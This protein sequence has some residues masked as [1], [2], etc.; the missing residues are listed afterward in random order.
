M[1]LNTG[2]QKFL[3]IIIDFT[4]G[5]PLTINAGTPRE[6]TY[7][8]LIEMINP[9][10]IPPIT[11]MF[12]DL[13]ITSADA[14]DDEK[15]LEVHCRFLVGGE[16]HWF[17]L[18]CSP[19]Y[20]SFEKPMR[21][22]GTMCDVS[23]YL[24]TSGDDLVYNEFKKK[25]NIKLAELNKGAVSLD[26]VL[27]KAYLTSI[28]KPFAQAGMYSAVFGAQG[29]L[30]CTPKGQN[31]GLS[32]E[33]F[34]FQKKKSIRINHLVSGSWVIAARTQE[35]LD[36]QL[37][38]WETLVQTVSGMANAFVTV[39]QEMDNSQNANKL[40]SQNVEEQIL[41]NN[42]YDIIMRSHT[43][44]E[45]LKKVLSLV[46][47]YFKL[48]RIVIKDIEEISEEES[49]WYTDEKYKSIQIDR[50][51]L[52]SQDF[53]NISN[54]LYNVSSSF[55]D[56]TSN[57]L[58]KYSIKSYAVFKLFDSGSF[59]GMIVYETI[60][61]QHNWT[62]RER[63][64]LRNISQIISSILMR[65]RAQKKLEESQERILQLAFYDSIFQVPNRARLNRDLTELLN[66]DADGSIISFKVTNTRNLSAVNGHSYTDLLLRSVA[67]YL[68]RLPIKNLGVY[69]FTNSIFILNLPYCTGTEARSL[70]EMLL[71]RFSKPW[72]FDNSEHYIHCSIGIAYYPVNGKT[73]EDVCKAASVAMYRAREFK[74][75][76][77]MFY[78]GSLVKSRTLAA[79]LEKRITD[80][81]TNG[82]TGFSLNFQPAFSSDDGTVSY[83]ES[84]IRWNDEK[85][86]SIPNSTLFPL[87]EN[88]GIS[89]LI[90]N[91]V[92][93]QSCIFCKSV[94]DGGYADFQV[95][96]NLTASEL[97]SS[98]IIAGVEH[99]LAVSGL[100]PESLILEIPVKANLSYN[101]ST[102]IL[103]E[104]NS[105]GVKI[106]IDSYGT[107]DISLKVLKNS[108][109]S[110]I[111]IPKT[112]LT[113]SDDEFDRELINAIIILAHCK[114][115]KICIKG[116]E[117]QTQL[118]AVRCHS[119][120]SVQGYYCSRPL[121][122]E[123]A[124]KILAGT[125]SRQAVKT[126]L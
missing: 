38:L 62:Q 4:R 111:N 85:Y 56:G 119:I 72:L 93:E 30:I 18:S 88:I 64:Q 36:E 75:N 10:D 116:I 67:Q 83:C 69:Y 80:C 104:L 106:A 90:D 42:V 96:V 53:P 68:R 59:G 3:N 110:I 71:Y 108:Y 66:K 31:P 114:G 120:D 17:F 95:S 78:S 19:I 50:S 11:E 81:I 97:Q 20:G 9:D 27:D 8:S 65:K 51:D 77:Y 28:Q 24:E 21:F 1:E 6:I 99:A 34:A 79:T 39:L 124:Y 115:I 73:A 52:T 113:E 14:A 117:D 5:F 101:D 37:P 98:G 55:S 12:T 41:L 118:N 126:P 70:A 58:E 15:K 47:E 46:G 7:P 61:A 60:A 109:V 125:V 107:E 26:E 23:M 48:D 13:S 100:S 16:Y 121:S 92:L 82:M 94:Q 102:N 40:L 63:K 86:G 122:A 76:S 33:N 49:C 89:H 105:L 35:M 84:L 123:E 112:L 45:G 22:E 57:E 87:A 2:N 29:R 32:A 91:W 103:S 54:D 43:A 74:K 44:Q 25:H